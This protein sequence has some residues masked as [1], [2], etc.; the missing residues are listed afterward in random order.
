MSL[1]ALDFDAVSGIAWISINRPQVLNAIDIPLAYA[2][3]DCILPLV[4]DRRVRCV[5][6]RGKGPAFMAGGDVGRFAED[7][8]Q[9]ETVVDEL[10][11]ALNPVI[12]A[13]RAMDAPV[14]AA[15]HGAVAGAGL[16]FVSAC[17]IVVAADSTK[18]L[19][20]YDRVGAAPDCGTTYFLPRILGVR[21]AAQF[22]LLSETLS[23]AEAKDIGLVNFLVPDGALSARIEEL[24]RQVAAGPTRAYGQYKRL[25]QDSFSSPLHDQLEAERKAFR[26]ATRTADFI[27]GVSAFLAKR[28]ANFKGR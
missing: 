4:D 5:V 17:D 10:L 19:M 25:V 24:A 21:R 6:L 26:A 23:A 12:E 11:G 1:A 20:A 13:L 27:E 14:L 16:A 18:F 3:R 28:R 2:L 8:D 22:M 9:A 7:F 15:V